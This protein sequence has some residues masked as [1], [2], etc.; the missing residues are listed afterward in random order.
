[1]PKAN[2][3]QNYRGGGREMNNVLNK[4]EGE[5]EKKKNGRHFRGCFRYFSS[6][7][8]DL[9]TPQKLQNLNWFYVHLGRVVWT[10]SRCKKDVPIQG[11][12]QEIFY[13]KISLFENLLG[14]SISQN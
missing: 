5:R 9:L 11:L 7:S 12:V 13:A 2:G 3:Q 1:V 6:S 4:R 14:R 10:R 8:I